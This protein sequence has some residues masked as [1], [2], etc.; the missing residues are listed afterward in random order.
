MIIYGYLWIFGEHELS[1]LISV[2][3]LA[4]MGGSYERVW[5]LGC[6]SF[7][8]FLNNDLMF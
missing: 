2:P 1:I 8:T 5:T 6:S 7:V 3:Y 4:H